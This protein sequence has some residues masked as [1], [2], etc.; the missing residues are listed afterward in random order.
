MYITFWNW[1][2]YYYFF[3]LSLIP[4]RWS[5]LL[6][7]SV[8]WSYLLLS[9]ISC[10]TVCLIFLSL[11]DIWIVSNFWLLWI[12]LLWTFVCIFLCKHSFHFINI[13]YK[14]ISVFLFL[15]MDFFCLYEY[16]VMNGLYACHSCPHL[17]E[18]F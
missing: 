6:H 7:V 17:W 1:F 15:L 12:K 3:L 14:Y 9:I 11:R 4:W 5:K 18:L 8:V 10:T 13:F 2:L 16:N